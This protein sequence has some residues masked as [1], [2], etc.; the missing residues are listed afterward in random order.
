MVNRGEEKVRVHMNVGSR[1]IHMYSGNTYTSNYAMT[2]GDIFL[3][4]EPGGDQVSSLFY[5]ILT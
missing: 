5:F 1:N 3:L 4:C 2:L